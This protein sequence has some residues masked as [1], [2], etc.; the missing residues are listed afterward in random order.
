L[1]GTSIT[2]TGTY[3]TDATEVTIGGVAVTEFTVVDST[4]IT[5]TTDAN[6]A[7]SASVLVTTPSGTNDETT[8]FLY[9]LPIPEIASVSPSSGSTLGGTSIT[10]TGTYFTDAT[11]VT[12]G[13]V[14]VT[15]F[16]VVDSTTITATTDANVAGS[17]SVLVTTPSGTNEA[18]SLFEYVLV[19][20]VVS[21]VSPSSGST[22]GGTS[23][24]ITGTYF[25]DATEVTIGGVA[26]TEFTVVDSTTITATT[27]AN[28]AG[29]AS[30][31]V[32]TPSGTNEAN[33]L[34]EYVV[35]A[36]T[37][38][39][40]SPS[41]GS[42]LGGTSIAI[43]GTYFTDATAVTIGDVAVAEFTV[44]NSTA[45]VATTSANVVGSASVLVTTPSGTNEANSLFEYVETTPTAVSVSPSSGSISGGTSI[46]ITGT[47]FVDVISVTIGGIA[48]TEFTVVNSTTI[49]AT[50]DA[51]VAGPASV[52]ITT[53]SG[54]N[55]TNSFF[56]Y[57]EN[58]P[59]VTSV[60]PS[61][62]FT[63]GGAL[64]T[65][66]GT[67]FAD[68]TEVT[69][70]GV[71]VVEFTV[72]DSTT[73][74]ATTDANVAGSASVLV[75]TSSGTNDA[76]SLFEYVETAPTV[77]SVSP[78]G[79]S[80][81]GGTSIEI[82]GTN[83]AGTT[84]VT[85]GGV[86]VTEFTVVDSTTI[87]ATTDANVAGSASVLITT[88]SGTNDANSSFEYVEIA[89][90]VSS[91][92]PSRGS[93]LGGTSITITGASFTGA[94]S[95][96][97]GGVSVASFIVVN[98]TTITAITS[99]RSA[100]ST[101]VFV[102]TPSGT[103]DDPGYL[104]LNGTYSYY[105]IV[106]GRPAYFNQDAGV[107]IFYFTNANLSPFHETWRIGT[108][109]YATDEISY[110]YYNAGNSEDDLGPPLSDWYIYKSPILLSLSVGVCNPTPTPTPTPTP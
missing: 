56:E 31:L 36:P 6:V 98:S 17:A 55:E 50:T 41:S 11:E 24:T 62:G 110:P 70:G 5:A 7:G 77:L 27:D 69:I 95:V 71:A 97:I 9:T 21:S 23:I 83:F 37:V 43:I 100:G 105:A 12:I 20:P 15:E 2:I 75:T 104:I 67:Y 22:L 91:V 58:A 1:G 72:I 107:Y 66:T 32:T 47:Y 16:T 61:S 3:F 87:T 108:D 109:P 51:N 78:S 73:I 39:S 18:N 28:V 102:T 38:S 74:T 103:N 29:S 34:F 96:E 49:T 48:A 89:P 82:T 85:I 4:I 101:S 46:T 57:I 59:T 13:G 80:T 40:L 94:T 84:E 81:L 10:I 68:V 60:S 99:A 76:N 65:I 8:I 42:T 64:I 19:P 14:A 35:T 53:P 52:L 63:S 90:T 92:S 106:N 54:T 86:A 45:I 26:V 44:V 25:A 93:T 79:G 88:P 33:S 30:V